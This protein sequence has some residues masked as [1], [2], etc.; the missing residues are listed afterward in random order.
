MRAHHFAINTHSTLTNTAKESQFRGRMI[1]ARRK[2]RRSLN[3]K[4]KTKHKTRKEGESKK[5]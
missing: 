5:Q 1:R 3:V 4:V 2:L